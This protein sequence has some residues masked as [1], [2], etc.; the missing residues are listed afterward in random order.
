V[1]HAELHG[2]LG[3]DAIDAE[4]REDILT[5]TVFGVL[6]AAGAWDV[7]FSW[8]GRAHPIGHTEPLHIAASESDEQRYWFWPRLHDAEPDLVVH[9]GRWL[10][11]IEAKYHSGKSGKGSALELRGARADQLVREWRACA[12]DG[13]LSAY[14]PPLVQAI[15]SCARVLVYLVKR[16]R[17][18]RELRAVEASVAQAPDA[19]MYL[20]TWEDLDEVLATCEPV[21]ALWPGELR[22]MLKRRGLAAFRGFREDTASIPG[23]VAKLGA[24]RARVPS[25]G[26]GLRTAFSSASS[27]LL[28]LL[29]SWRFSHELAHPRTGW[30]LLMDPGSLPRLASL[31]ERVPRFHR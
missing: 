14:P 22:R 25:A 6:F 27:P 15:Q 8:L 10:V 29:G 9:A 3:S 13:D 11:T 21:S 18:A 2:K 26:F 19:R 17:W 31:V 28:A 5:S 16:G 24:W 20:L 12:P 30:A 1:L 7:L 23:S 4:R